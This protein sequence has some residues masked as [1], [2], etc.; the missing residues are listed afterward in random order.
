LGCARTL[1]A[2]FNAHQLVAVQLW[3]ALDAWLAWRVWRRGAWIALL[4]LTG[5]AVARRR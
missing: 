3:L 1:G 2:S 5:I 4:L